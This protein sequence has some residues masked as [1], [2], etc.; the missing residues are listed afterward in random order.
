MDAK[1]FR[2]AHHIDPDYGQGLKNAVKKGVEILAYDVLLD[3][4]GI[5]L[6]RKLPF[7]L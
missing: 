4:K 2:P 5:S 7:D 6:N 3:L 1:F